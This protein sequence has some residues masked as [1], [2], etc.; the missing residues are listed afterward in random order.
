[1]DLYTIC[2]WTGIA[3]F[4]VKLF[5][6]YK[7]LAPYFTAPVDVNERYIKGKKDVWAVVTGASEGAGRDWAIELSK[8]G[9]NIILIARTVSKLEKV[10]QELN[11]AVK[12]KILP[13]D[14]SK[15]DDEQFALELKKDL[16]DFNIAALVNNVGVI[17]VERFE[18]ISAQTIANHIK[19]NMISMSVMVSI[20]YEK[21]YQDAKK[22]NR[23]S[24]IINMS[25]FSAEN[26][27]AFY[28]IYSSTKKYIL[29]FTTILDKTY[30]LHQDD[31][32]DY[33]DI[34]AIRPYFIKTQMVNFKSLPFTV[35]TEQFQKGVFSIIGKTNHASG[36]A[37][38]E[39]Y[40][41]ISGLV[42]KYLLDFAM[43]HITWNL[44]VQ[45]G[46]QKKDN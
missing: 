35:T 1:M 27:S 4:A 5:E 11:P 18:K 28:Q 12:S 26:H 39:L 44:V 29:H 33:V 36:T 30:K 32:K 19:I 8:R 7:R 25:S 14:F 45:L 6:L 13:K 10:A 16:Q 2:L 3:I 15:C 43:P 21:L 41:F 22:D 17:D 20:L 34:L 37:I 42:P 31:F 23:K 24:I 38:H 46:F 9:F 40:S